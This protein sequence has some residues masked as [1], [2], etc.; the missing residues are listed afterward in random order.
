[1]SNP[2]KLIQSLLFQR[3]HFARKVNSEGYINPTAARSTQTHVEA[4]IWEGTRIVR[5]CFS[6]RTGLAAKK[7]E[8]KGA[9]SAHKK[10]DSQDFP[11]RIFQ[12]T[13]QVR[14]EIHRRWGRRPRGSDCALARSRLS[15]WTFGAGG[16]KRAGG[17]REPSGARWESG[18]RF[19][20][21]D[22]CDYDPDHLTFDRLR[23]RDG[24]SVEEHAG[25]VLRDEQLGDGPGCTIWMDRTGDV[26]DQMGRQDP[27]PVRRWHVWV[28]AEFFTA[29]PVIRQP[30][31]RVD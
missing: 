21:G 22:P 9:E 27:V 7:F 10:A 25:C 8:E 5:R 13:V 18:G 6:S 24:D 2:Q 29:D 3:E 19:Q 1:M 15:L 11:A 16:E 4:S 28:S 20:E 14:A 12:L 26:Y 31:R 23:D 30:W 17:G